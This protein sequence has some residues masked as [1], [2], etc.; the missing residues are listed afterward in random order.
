MA[1]E[2]KF[3]YIPIKGIINTSWDT[4]FAQAVSSIGNI[5]TVT[6]V[7]AVQ[8]SPDEEIDMIV[9]DTEEVN[10]VSE[11]IP[12][13]RAKS[14]KQTIYTNQRMRRQFALKSKRY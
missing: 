3:L 5:K 4:I 6:E 9:I 13:L 14:P 12:L 11:L 8:M 1:K 2:Y 10:K 7:E